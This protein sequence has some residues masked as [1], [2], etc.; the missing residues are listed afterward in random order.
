MSPLNYKKRIKTVHKIVPGTNIGIFKKPTVKDLYDVFSQIK[1]HLP[2]IDSKVA[3]VSVETMDGTEIENINNLRGMSE[4]EE[5]GNL[6]I[7]KND[8]DHLIYFKS[9]NDKWAGGIGCG[10]QFSPIDKDNLHR[11]FNIM[12]AEVYSAIPLILM[13]LATVNPL[14]FLGSFILGYDCYRRH[15]KTKQD[16]LGVEVG[17]SEKVPNQVLYTL[18]RLSKILGQH[19]ERQTQNPCLDDLIEEEVSEKGEIRHPPTYSSEDL[20]KYERFIEHI[21]QIKL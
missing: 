6:P 12:E 1:D 2:L 21:K 4:T 8:I 19:I 7:K 18:K 9:E 3:C 5:Y 14:M 10:V 15:N 16:F 17:S 13:G 20:Q 11:Y